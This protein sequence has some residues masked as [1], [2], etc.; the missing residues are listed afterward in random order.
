MGNMIKPRILALDFGSTLG[1]A[2][3]ASDGSVHYDTE[4]FK[5][6][7]SE[8]A[9]MRWLRFHDWLAEMLA[10]IQP[11]AV[12]FEE[13]VGFPPKNNGQDARV[14]HSFASHLMSFCEKREVPYRGVSVIAQP[15]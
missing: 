14:Y 13:C 7:F 8:G 11:D 1:W 15:S 3:R 4:T 5:T 6:K 9:G 10:S 12:Y 2:A